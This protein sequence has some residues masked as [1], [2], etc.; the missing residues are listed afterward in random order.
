MTTAADPLSLRL[1]RALESAVAG[2][3]RGETGRWAAAQ[4]LVARASV[5][6][7]NLATGILTARALGAEGRGELVALGVGT[8]F[9]SGI[10]TLGLPS[11][12]VYNFRRYPAE[13][14]RLLGAALVLAFTLGLTA[15]AIGA[16]V[17][18]GYLGA[19]YSPDVVRAAQVLMLHAPILLVTPICNRALEAI[20]E[21]SVSNW[22]R[23]LSPLITLVLLGVLALL[24]EMTPLRAALSYIA[25]S[26]TL[27][28]MLVRLWQRYAPQLKSFATSVKRLMSFGTRSYGIDLLGTVSA[29]IDQILVVGVLAPALVGAYAV[30]LSAARLINVVHVSVATVLFPKMASRSAD[31]V[32]ETVGVAL[33]CTVGLLALGGAVVFAAGPLLLGLLYGDEFVAATPLLRVLV[34]EVVL[35]GATLIL[36]QSFM[37]LDK[38]GWVAVFQAA[39]LVM[40]VPLM[41]VLVP[42]LGLIGAGFALLFSTLARLVSVVAA[43]PLVLGKPVPR[44]LLTPSDVRA[45]LRR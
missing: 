41:I 2:M 19:D 18:P 30:A 27:V 40:A 33:R 43:Y 15:A 32:V 31:E 7:L 44:F 13:R 24:G 42:R 23:L 10:L 9:F 28:W 1:R 36:A 38:P 37:A 8:A 34:V 12:I 16:L 21:F 4:T 35:S 6:V 14:R 22:V 26:V 39:G 17:L 5:L 45:L 29:Q 11:S 20:G 3:W 25:G